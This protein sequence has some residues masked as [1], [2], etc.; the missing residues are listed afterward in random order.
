MFT[1]LVEGLGEIKSLRKHGGVQ[2]IAI[3][4]DLPPAELKGGDSVS[5]NGVCLTL[6]S[7]CEPE[8][9][10]RV[11]AVSETLRR[12]TLKQL[13]V[14]DKVH[15]ERALRSG[16]R[17]GG[18]LVQ[19]HVDDLGRVRRSER[20]G[21]ETVLDIGIPQRLMRYLVEKGSVCIDGVS[22]TVGATGGDW[23]R[24]HIVPATA[25]WTLL[26]GYRDG[27]EVNLEVDLIAK[28]VESLM[29][30]FGRPGAVD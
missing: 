3:R 9:T 28:Y 13:R 21:G 29:G 11:Q 10:F 23:F 25:E 19:G 5:V 22:L 1:G 16:D 30:S 14:A 18:H 12:T 7:D 27:R 4:S 20:R 6:I 8:G 15:L 2:E 17:F 26:A 24:V